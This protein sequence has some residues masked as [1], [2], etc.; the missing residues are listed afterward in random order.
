MDDGVE[1]IIYIKRKSVPS[2]LKVIA[3]MISLIEN[4]SQHTLTFTSW[5]YK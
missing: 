5:C 3:A 1:Q 4:S 2:P